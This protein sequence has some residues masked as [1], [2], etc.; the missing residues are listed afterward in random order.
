MNIWLHSRH[1]ERHKQN[2]AL[3]WTIQ[4]HTQLYYRIT[5]ITC[6]HRLGH[7]VSGSQILSRYSIKYTRFTL[8]YSWSTMIYMCV[9][10]G[11]IVLWGKILKNPVYLVKSAWFLENWPRFRGCTPT[12]SLCMNLPSSKVLNF[13]SLNK[14][15]PR[16]S[17]DGWLGKTFL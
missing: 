10:T 3:R 16:W 14:V 4:Q 5:S 1:G 6:N 17:Q 15:W 7:R 12:P 8:N 13:E 11:L 2:N 9:I